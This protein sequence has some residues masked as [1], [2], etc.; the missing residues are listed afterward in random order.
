MSEPL[1]TPSQEQIDKA[2][3]TDF[4][5]RLAE[6]TGQAFSSYHDLYH[7]SITEIE[8]FWQF[9]REYTGL[10][11]S[12]DADTVRTGDE[13][14]N[15][16][17]FPGARLNFAENLLRYRDSRP[18]LIAHAEGRSPRRLSYRELYDS[19]AAC[20]AGLRRLGVTKDDRV[21]GIVPNTPEAIIAMLATTAIGAIW[22]SCSPDFGFQG[23]LD[24]F[25]QIEPKVLFS[26]DGYRYNGKAIDSLDRVAH[27][28]D[29]IPSI[30]HAVIFGH[31][32]EQPRL[33]L[34]R[35]MPW[36]DLLD[37]DPS[38]LTFE[39]LPFD[40]PVYIMYSSGTTG[41]PK[42]IVHGAGGTL[43]QHA[44]EHILH[45]DV[46]RDDV[47]FY[48]TTCGWMMWNW[49]VGGLQA[50]ATLFLYDGSPT[51]PN[52]SVLWDAVD[53]EGITVFGTSPKYLSA[54][55]DRR[56]KPRETHDLS[57]LRTILSTGA[58]LSIAN[59]EYVYEHIK[60]DVQLASISGGTD[61]VS[62]F[63]LGCP[64]LPVYPGEI[65]CRGLG[66]KV[67]T[68][69]DRGEPVEYEVGELVC[70]AP[71]PSRPVFF[72]DDPDHR[73]YRAAYFDTYP[74]VWRHGDYIT[75][76]PR[77]GVIVHGRS[78]ATLNPGGVRI[79][80]AEIYGPVEAL[81]E[82]VDS[83]AVG[84]TFNGD[85]RVILFVVTADGVELD[86]NLRERI[87]AA[88]REQ[89]TPRHV[90]AKIIA[91]REIPHT[92]NG[93]K[94]EIAVTRILHG[95]DVGNRDALANPESLEAFRNLPELNEP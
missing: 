83:M 93:K 20:A 1:W 2:N 77:G 31:L 91:V 44:K 86:D 25:G 32:T 59:F 79:G 29:A 22:S 26:A 67:E 18:A 11:T 4:M 68:Y 78:D 66:M 74:G 81:P 75:I 95:Q 70:T 30:Q 90:P 24:R 12:G 50:G 5:R 36:D 17:W 7:Y 9:V 19:V 28:L 69:N 47:V 88:I 85:T 65:Q 10:I 89:R 40:H 48:F 13:I 46:T 15:S 43:L 57:S 58:P 73:K 3:L 61:I 21:A 92:L 53:R 27:V 8:P 64:I 33:D 80:T 42:C 51:H 37:G 82:I 60:P 34:P 35:A 62:C 94:V 23:V 38:E 45:T 71:F 39:Q 84:Q 6:K 56:V 54:L 41:K 72:W 76:T 16:E 49:L 52:L 55:E 14:W 63:M 87:R